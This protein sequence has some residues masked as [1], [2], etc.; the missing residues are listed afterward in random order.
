MASGALVVALIAPALAAAEP[1]FERRDQ[2]VTRADLFILRRADEILAD[3]TRWNRADTRVCKPED[4]TFSLFCAL[5]RACLDVLGEYQHRRAAL[6]EV[7]FIIEE[8]ADPKT[9]G[10]HRLMGWNNLPSTTFAD[11]KR[12]L[13]TATERVSAR[14]RAPPAAPPAEVSFPTADG[15]VVYA[16]LY[17]KGSRALVLAHGG[18][19]D[20]GSWAMQARALAQA[21]YRVLAID[22]RGRGRSR[23]G[24]ARSPSDDGSRHDVLAAV[25]YLRKTGARRVAVIG[26]SFGGGAAAQAALEAPGEIDRLVLLACEVDDPERLA[27]RKLFILARDDPGSD[28][29]PRLR[30]IQPQYDR[31]L[32]PKELVL[33]DGSAHAQLIFETRQGPRLMQEILRFLRQR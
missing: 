22:F 11:I 29:A 20:K 5:Q 8:R 3:P 12:V 4:R 15:G 7:R 25:R 27:V 13:A 16:D 26:A 31:A 19:F 6:Q 18:R 32:Q 23:G 28:G 14:L 21:G 1:D 17:G 10:G 30:G 33:L 24:P 2:P 9:L